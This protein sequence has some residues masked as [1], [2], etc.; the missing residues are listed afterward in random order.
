M[1]ISCKPFSL[2]ERDIALFVVRDECVVALPTLLDL[3]A[4][5]WKK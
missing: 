3:L 2:L 4:R 1:R 5:M